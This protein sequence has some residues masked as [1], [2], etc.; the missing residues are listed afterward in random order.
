MAE[1][2]L[3][4]VIAVA[5]QDVE[6]RVTLANVAVTLAN[7][8]Q[9]KPLQVDP[10]AAIEQ[11]IEVARLQPQ[12]VVVRERLLGDYLRTERAD[13]AAVIAGE[14]RRWGLRTA[15][16]CFSRPTRR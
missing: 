14:L 5:P 8:G 13:A 1:I 3:K 6:A 15:M 12:N 4:N 2:H 11:L 9:D 16:R 7:Q 10:P